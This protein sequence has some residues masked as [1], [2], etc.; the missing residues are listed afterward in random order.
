MEVPRFDQFPH[1]FL[2]Y[3]AFLKKLIDTTPL[4]LAPRVLAVPHEYV[5]FGGAYAEQ[6]RLV[7]E[8][9][10][11]VDAS[12]NIAERRAAPQ[13][14]L[15]TEGAAGSPS[16]TGMTHPG[17]AP[18][19]NEEAAPCHHRPGCR[20]SR[21]ARLR[22]SDEIAVIE[23]VI[24]QL[25]DY[26]A[27]GLLDANVQLRSSVRG[28]RQAEVADSGLAAAEGLNRRFA[29]VD[30]DQ[31]PIRIGLAKE[32]PER[33]RHEVMAVPGCHDAGN[34]PRQGASTHV[35]YYTS[36]WIETCRRSG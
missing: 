27:E 2:V 23:I 10:P 11:C 5:M 18:K 24:V 14:P 4:H 33:L 28:L 15:K 36:A 26:I 29:V 32:T 7:V 19:Q 13:C 21:Q 34:K 6:T 30:H 22:E 17:L 16:V 20:P 25:L 31:F 12:R 1:P 35:R 3:R 9:K 8:K